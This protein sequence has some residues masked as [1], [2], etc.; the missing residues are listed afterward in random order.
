MFRRYA[1]GTTVPADKS[2][3][4]LEAMLDKHGATEFAIH[5]DAERDVLDVPCA[6]AVVRVRREGGGVKTWL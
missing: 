2:R 4:E 3:H 1:E 5:R 6:R